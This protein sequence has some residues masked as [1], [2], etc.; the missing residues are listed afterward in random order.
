MIETLRSRSHWYRLLAGV[1]AEEPQAAFLREL[2]SEACLASL[3]ELGVNFGDDFLVE[4]EE[5]LLEELAAEYTMLFVA[6]GGF[7][8]MESVRLQG[9]LRQSA[10]NETRDDYAAEG[11]SVQPGRFITFDDHLAVEMQ[12]VAALLERQADALEQDD[13]T[14]AMRLEKTVKRFWVKHLGCWVRGYASLV[15]EAAAH[16]FYREMAR[17][18]DAF[19]IAELEVMG[20]EIDDQDGGR[21]RAPKPESV[22]Q[23]MQC[24]GAASS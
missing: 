10:V 6:P 24:G 13:A 18:L 4:S 17:L 21:W 22:T 9:G 23:P 19:A 7:P 2:R 16:T 20:L 11:F 8:P 3:A 5:A 12:F 14:E 15:E 1:F